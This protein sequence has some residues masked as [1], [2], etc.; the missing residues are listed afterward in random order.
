MPRSVPRLTSRGLAVFAAFGFVV[1][2]AT[3]T[4]TPEL[5][6]LAVVT[7]VPLLLAPWLAGRR[8]RSALTAAEFHAHV[9]P[10]TVEVGATMQIHLSVTHRASAGYSFPSLGLAPTEHQWRIRGAATGPSR[11]RGHLAP[12]ADSL[13]VL[14]SPA[15][16]RTGT[17]RLPVPTGRRGVLE[18]PPQPSWT[19][20]P[21]G[22]FAA[23]GPPTPAVI[24]VVYPVPVAPGEPLPEIMTPVGGT[25]SSGHSPSGSGVG[26][27]EGI[28]PYVVGDRLSLLHWSSKARYGA[29][30]VRQFGTEGH[31]TVSVAIDDRPGVHQR[32]RF[33]QLVA[34]TLGVLTEATEAG[35]SV[36]LF[37]LSGRRYTFGPGERGRAEARLVLAE[38]QPSGSGARAGSGALPRGTLLLTT[39]TGADRL[40]PLGTEGAPPGRIGSVVGGPG[41]QVAVV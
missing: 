14:P 25:D 37:T 9:E 20:D 41:P 30:F 36:H 22:L 40:A 2:V 21:F 16:G 13:L 17:C 23:A 7:G 15:R 3:V 11:R 26:D 38:L 5:A 34:V 33:E 8:A 24:A 39:R 31:V 12:A 6:P 35:R 29:W 10:G 4:S 19:S 18:L 32:I 1:V 28:R 27:L